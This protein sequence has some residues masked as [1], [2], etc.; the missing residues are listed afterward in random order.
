MIVTDLNQNL[1]APKDFTLVR[2]YASG[3][4][5]VIN[6]EQSVYQI[7]GRSATNYVAIYLNENGQEVLRTSWTKP[8]E[9]SGDYSLNPVAQAAGHVKKV[10]W[11]DKTLARIFDGSFN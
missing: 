8:F 5:L 2:V 3:S 9:A 6:Y 4:F 1:K 7:Q 10:S 11:L